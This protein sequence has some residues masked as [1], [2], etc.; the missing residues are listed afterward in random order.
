[1]RRTPHLL[2]MRDPALHDDSADELCGA[3]LVHE[4]RPLGCATRAFAV[5]DRSGR[6]VLLGSPEK[7]LQLALHAGSQLLK[8]GA[9]IVL[10]TVQCEKPQDDPA[11][12]LQPVSGIQW[13]MR[14]RD[15]PAFL[16]L[17]GSFDATLSRLGQKTRSNLRY[18]RRRAEAELNC[19][20]VPEAQ[21]SLEEVIKFNRDST[22]PVAE[23]VLRWRISVQSQIREPYLMGLQDGEGRWLS[24]IGGR[25]F[26][27]ATE[28]LWQTNRGDLPRHSIVSAM[29]SYHMEH[30]I[31]RGADRLYIEGGTPHSMQHSFETMPTTD[32]ILVRSRLKR[33]M[34]GFAR[35]YVPPDNMLAEMLQDPETEWHTC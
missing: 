13:A 34:S 16:Q 26:G 33:S 3:L 7:R 18:Y 23:R 24:L 29:R 6:G 20:F 19:R 17:A 21:L 28:I 31:G 11:R 27:K 9:K 35:R 10:L 22:F 25:R 14:T 4:F 2:L 12:F 32:I 5:T 1:M 8:S 15:Q 30:E